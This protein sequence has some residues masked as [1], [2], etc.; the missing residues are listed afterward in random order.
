[1]QDVNPCR[2]A[3][4]SDYTNESTVRIAFVPI[5]KEFS[6]SACDTHQVHDLGDKVIQHYSNATKNNGISVDDLDIMNNANEFDIL[7]DGYE[8]LNS[9]DDD[10]YVDE[11]DNIFNLPKS[12]HVFLST[13]LDAD[14]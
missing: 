10:D 4:A 6:C 14:V 11:D 12:V 2:L 1:M 3:L 5:D 13:N 7:N 8:D 9:S